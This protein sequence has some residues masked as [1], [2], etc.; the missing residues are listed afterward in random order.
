MARAYCMLGQVHG[1]VN[2]LQESLQNFD[3]ALALVE[4]S[5]RSDPNH[6]EYR[7]LAALIYTDRGQE[8]LLQRPANAEADLRPALTHW[9]A[10]SGEYP[11]P[12]AI[13]GR[14]Y[15]LLLLS[16][17]LDSLSRFDEVEPLIRQ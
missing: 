4:D 16:N 9:D 6:V 1:K 2:D 17:V 13:A 11:D 14:V 3:Q 8:Q 7:R 10:L 15:T 5:P 12:Y